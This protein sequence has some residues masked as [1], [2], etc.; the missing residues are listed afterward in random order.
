MVQP[1][2]SHPVTYRMTA[3]EAR[4]MTNV[5]KDHLT[6][7]ETAASPHMAHFRDCLLLIYQ[8]QGWQ[9]LKYASWKEYAIAE[10]E[11]G[12]SQAY[13]LLDAAQ[14]EADLKRV[15]PIG[16]S[17]A[18]CKESPMGD[19]STNCKESPIG[20]SSTNS[21]KLVESHAR[22]VK[23]LPDAKARIKAMSKARANGKLTAKKLASV[24]QDVLD[25]ELSAADRE[26]NRQVKAEKDAM[27]LLSAALKVLVTAGVTGAKL[28]IVEDARDEFA[29]AIRGAKA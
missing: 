29:L 21:N 6:K 18:N 22:E 15:S 8:C 17:Y 14:M 27:A 19:S 2:K 3:S 12:K 4:E 10:Y 23:K 11:V 9:A 16:E 28:R 5:A 26:V 20:D 25:E 24:V 1:L 7:A 13:R